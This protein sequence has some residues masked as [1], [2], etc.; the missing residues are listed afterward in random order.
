MIFIG[1]DGCKKGWFAVKLKDGDEWEARVFQDIGALWAEFTDASVIL[2]DVPIGLK[3]FGVEER[4]CDVQARKLLGRGRASSVFRP[5]CRKAVY[6]SMGQASDVNF[7][8][9]GKYL[10][11]QTLN[12]LRKIREMDQF[13]SVHKSARAVIR[14]THPEICFW[15]LAGHRPMKHRK[16]KERGF[17]ERKAVLEYAFPSSKGIIEDALKTYKRKDLAKDDIL[18][19]LAAAITAK[20]GFGGFSTIPG[21]PQVDSKGLPMEMVYF[22]PENGVGSRLDY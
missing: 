9:N 16:R 1:V 15:A 19:A 12:I 8:V 22:A 18:D 14:E 4:E 5:P 2:I 10:P 6:S 13:L 21:I 3:E 20:M 7:K 11:R 17:L